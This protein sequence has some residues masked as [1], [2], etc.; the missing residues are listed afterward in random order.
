MSNEIPCPLPECDGG[1][2]YIYNAYA[3]DPLTPEPKPC[4][5]CAGQGSIYT[6]AEVALAN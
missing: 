4:E 1:I 3:K 6:D 2:V 5:F